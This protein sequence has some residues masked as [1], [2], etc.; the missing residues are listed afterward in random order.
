MLNL[1]GITDVIDFQYVP[2]GNAQGLPP[3]VECQHGEQECNG[4]AAEACA[5]NQTG[6][7][8]IQYMPFVACIDTKGQAADTVDAA[9]VSKCA[10]K[11]NLDGDDINACWPG[12]R[13]DTL[14]T[15]MAKATPTHDYVPYVLVNGEEPPNGDY[16]KVLSQVCKDIK[17]TKPSWCTSETQQPNVCWN[18]AK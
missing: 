17:G 2:Y 5:I 15:Q 11:A 13:G 1:E 16:T 8:P 12:S 18:S 3:N 14:I 9:L 10:K 7:A 6:Y 4:N